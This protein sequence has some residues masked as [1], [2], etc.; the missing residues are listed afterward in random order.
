MFTQLCSV[1]QGDTYVAIILLV[2]GMACLLVEGFIP[3]FGFFGIAGLV[4]TVTGLTLQI[5]IGESFMQTLIIIISVLVFVLLVILVFIRSAK[6][7]LLKKS[8][9]IN[10]QT[11][12][13]VDYGEDENNYGYLLGAKGRL[14]SPCKPAGKAEIN[15][16]VYSVISET[17]YLYVNT[18]VE[19]DYVEGS[20]IYVKKVDKAH[21]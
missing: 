11:A 15:G 16:E 7:G 18:E 4:L 14:V 3:G 8:P 19:V 13:P 6:Y 5:I 10:D 20:S 21:E 17:E 9:L 1:F 2:L 12:V